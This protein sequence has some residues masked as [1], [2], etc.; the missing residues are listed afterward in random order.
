VYFRNLPSSNP[1][2]IDKRHNHDASRSLNDHSEPRCI[3]LSD[4]VYEVLRGCL[5]GYNDRTVAMFQGDDSSL[6]PLT[7]S[8]SNMIYYAQSTVE[9]T[10]TGLRLF[11]VFP[12]RPRQRFV[13]EHLRISPMATIFKTLK[14]LLM[15]P[16]DKDEPGVI[17]A[18]GNYYLLVG[19]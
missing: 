10:I 1:S 5:E 13:M 12:L 16:S 7:L 15:L 19:T 2:I 8:A 6:P 17:L 3:C 9:G 11:F 18:P 14:L 4:G